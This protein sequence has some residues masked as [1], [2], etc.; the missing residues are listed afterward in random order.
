[1]VNCGSTLANM[2]AST[3]SNQGVNGSVVRHRTEVSTQLRSDVALLS[4]MQKES[5]GSS[6]QSFQSSTGGA[7]ASGKEPKLLDDSEQ[8]IGYNSFELLE[9][10][11]QGSFGKVF[12][13]RRNEEE[14]AMKVLKKNFLVKNKQLKYAITECN[15]LKLANHPFIIKL[16]YAFQTP[17]NLYMVMDYCPGGDLAFH[18]YKK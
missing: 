14:F 5:D 2:M 4:Q 1:M 3:V 16:H 13:V 17:E 12:K 11:G 18:Q 15:I 6:K 7:T 10:V 9:M 8:G